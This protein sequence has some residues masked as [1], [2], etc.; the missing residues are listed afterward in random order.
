[1]SNKVIIAVETIAIVLLSVVVVVYGQV[2]WQ[3]YHQAP[4]DA[5]ETKVEEVSSQTDVKLSAEERFRIL[6]ELAANPPEGALTSEERV[7]VLSDLEKKDSAP[8]ITKEER[9]ELLNNL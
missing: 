1:M 7:Q 8:A 9:L 5:I 2:V 3:R 6:E 4:V